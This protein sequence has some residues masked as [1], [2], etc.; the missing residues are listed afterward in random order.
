MFL[1]PALSF[2]RAEGLCS[3]V[4]AVG[5]QSPKSQHGQVKGP[6]GVV[7]VTSASLTTEWLKL[8]HKIG[9]SFLT[10]CSY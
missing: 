3:L 4:C 6:E 10:T 5:A 1:I 2:F 8:Q 9:R 7:T